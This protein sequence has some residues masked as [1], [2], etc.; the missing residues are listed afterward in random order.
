[1]LIDKQQTYREIFLFNINKLEEP[2]YNFWPKCKD[3][4][5]RVPLIRLYQIIVVLIVVLEID[6]RP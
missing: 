4:R 5:Q 6:L 1:M 3:Y 2:A